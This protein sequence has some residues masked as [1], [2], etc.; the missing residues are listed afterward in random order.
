MILQVLS[1]AGQ[2]MRGCDAVLRQRGAVADAGKHQQLR[3][4]KRAGRKD[5]FA[6]GANLPDILALAVFDADRTLALDQDAGGVRLRL[7]AQ[8]GA[9]C[10]ERMAVAACRAPALAIVL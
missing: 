8:I 4:L 1:D 7:D 5:H 10:P 2:M 9:R 6:A 3:A